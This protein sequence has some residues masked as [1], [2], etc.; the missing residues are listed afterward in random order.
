MAGGHGEVRDDH[1][2]DDDDDNDQVPGQDA[3]E[4]RYRPHGHRM[5]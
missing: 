3:G 1:V 2:D 4:P 5:V